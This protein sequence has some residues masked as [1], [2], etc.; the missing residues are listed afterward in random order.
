VRLAYT[1]DTHLGVYGQPVPD[2]REV[3]RGWDQLLEEAELAERVG[4]DGVW[5]PERHMRTEAFVGSPITLAAA[6]AA[7]TTRVG[8]ATAVMNPTYHDPMQLAEDLA[9][10]D[11]LSKG[12]L[13][14]GAG[15]GYHSDYFRLF[16]VPRVKTGER[17]QEAMDVIERAWGGERFTFN[18]RHFAYDDVLL[19]PGPYQNPRPPIW[20]GAFAHKA[21]ERALQY[22]GWI[23]WWQPDPAET[24]A[25]VDYWRERA[26]SIGKTNWQ[27]C[28]DLEGWIGD[29]VGAVRKRHGDRWL[30]EAGFYLAQDSKTRLDPTQG[31]AAMERRY[32]QFGPSAAWIERIGRIE[33][34]YRPDWLNVRIRNPRSKA[35]DPPDKKETMEAIQ[36]LG[37]E[38][39]R[40]FQR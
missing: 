8:I 34:D 28:M 30:H 16:N 4:F 7:R 10:I 14:F 15:V 11:N 9:A 29:D 5:L 21:I 23:L 22:D 12:R 27:I 32:L 24:K 26:A 6:I 13:I 19:T 36:R 18:G 25:A 39:I 17:F 37:E 3:A 2:A 35:G 1:L 20:I 38:V 33:T 31:L 40:V